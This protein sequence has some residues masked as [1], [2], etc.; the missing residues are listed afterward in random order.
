MP[1]RWATQSSARPRLF[2]KTNVRRPPKPAGP[3]DFPVLRRQE[4][5]GAVI[6]RA[7]QQHRWTIARA[8]HMGFLVADRDRIFFV[9]I[10]HVDDHGSAL[11][12]V[13]APPAIAQAH[14]PMGLEPAFLLL[15]GFAH[16]AG[17]TRR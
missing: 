3:C 11:G 10:S 13:A 12:G 14:R 4:K 16:Q 2:S 5:P 17:S 7:I 9:R 6:R 1:R 15:A 8:L